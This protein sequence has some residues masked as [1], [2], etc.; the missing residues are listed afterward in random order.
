MD[1]ERTAERAGAA[2]WLR[3]LPVA[4]AAACVLGAG[5]A[6]P[7]GLP[8]ARP[9]WAQTRVEGG[10]LL[11][12]L[13]IALCVAAIPLRRRKICR[14]CGSV[15][16]KSQGL[17][18]AVGA[19][20]AA[21]V[22]G[23]AFWI[24]VARAPFSAP[25]LPAAARPASW[26]GQALRCGVDNEL[27]WLW[28]TA[29]PSAESD[30]KADSGRDGLWVRLAELGPLPAPGAW[31]HLEGMLIR[32]RGRLR[33]ERAAWHPTG[34]RRARVEIRE[35]LR[36]RLH[37]ALPAD[38]AGLA[39]ALLLGESRAAP[40]EIRA[41][42]R[43]L[44]LV[45]LLC[46]SG[47]HL[48]LWDAWLRLLLRG[49]TRVL[50]IPLLCAIA[51]LAGLQAPVLRA[52]ATLLLRDWCVR[53]GLQVAP[54]RLW[55]AAVWAELLLWPDRPAALGFV[56]SYSAT[57]ALL[58]MPH[59][60]SKRPLVA[61]LTVGLAATLGAQPWLFRA[62]GMLQPWS[63]LLS[64]C[65]ALLLPARI[66]LSAAA[67]LPGAA[68]PVAGALALVR[69]AEDFC[70]GLLQQL[71]GVPW[72]VPELSTLGVMLG[73]AVAV[74]GLRSALHGQRR[75]A[76][77]AALLAIALICIPGESTPG[78]LALPVGHG[79]AIVIGG[80]ER[81]LMFDC[82]SAELAPERQVRRLLLPE[83]RR[84]GWH[85]P[86][87]IVLS[88]SDHDHRNGLPEL[89]ALG[90]IN[91]LRSTAGETV[92]LR[93]I[94]G[95]R[96][97]LLGLEPG[98][99]GAAN[100]EGHALELRR[101]E[102]R[103]VLL[104]DPWGHAL[105]DLCRRLPPGPVDLLLLPHHGRTTEGVAELLEH[106]QPRECWI[107]CAENA[108]PAVLSLLRDSGIRVRRTGPEAL[109]LPF[110]APTEDSR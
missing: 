52:L 90:S 21:A 73:S 80:P 59:E 101:G 23:A 24:G 55:A 22:I 106:L 19:I 28:V 49:S 12:L 93:S 70:L 47:M 65:F 34:Q 54:L 75:R 56:L 17:A 71:P 64:P 104:G 39:C 30:R 37:A 91:V 74:L 87:S 107:P 15:A 58:A 94:G 42:Y 66:F 25:S 84:R 98:L 96:V 88:H 99:R 103:V 6:Q 46:I 102:R 78:V 1:V 77:A 110:A 60:R 11:L 83:L 72:A 9:E 32:E 3:G 44:G 45:H 43:D 35:A 40:G 95:W 16:T 62:T 89:A 81:S 26:E 14:L 69:V 20:A 13:G 33:L 100:A 27:A 76:S 82:G 51:A 8:L 29:P 2:A 109:F 36:L 105:L 86:D 7:L 18:N 108:E 67:L 41:A 63:P 97:R 50:R 61:I 53:R 4:A 85:R 10:G 92:P 48:W 5:L 79:L 68:A 31:I 57:F 38:D